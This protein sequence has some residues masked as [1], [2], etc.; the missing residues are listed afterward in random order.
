MRAAPHVPLL[1]PQ[2]AYRQHAEESKDPARMGCAIRAFYGF[3]CSNSR[4]VIYF[5]GWNG[6]EDESDYNSRPARVALF[7]VG[8]ENLQ[9]HLDGVTIEHVDV[10]DRPTP[11]NT[12][13]YAGESL[14]AALL[15]SHSLTT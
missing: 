7:R 11:K 2:V 4:E 5:N 14:A 10:F 15:L 3:A 8:L 1:S 6:K 13:V 9:E 12:F